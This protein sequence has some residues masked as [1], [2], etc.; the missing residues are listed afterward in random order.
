[1]NLAML[2]PTMPS[3]GRACSDG[4]G[5]ALGGGSRAPSQK[6]S[7][8]WGDVLTVYL[9][10]ADLP[11]IDKIAVQVLSTSASAITVTDL[12]LSRLTFAR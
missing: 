7:R 5:R 10:E 4:C 9:T 2:S 1:M 6:G 11:K 12:C 8:C 3:T